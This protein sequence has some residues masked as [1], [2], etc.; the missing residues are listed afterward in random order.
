MKKMLKKITE[1]SIS[2]GVLTYEDLTS[3]ISACRVKDVLPDLDFL[4]G[5]DL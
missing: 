4:A 1:V 5:S 2:V 3:S